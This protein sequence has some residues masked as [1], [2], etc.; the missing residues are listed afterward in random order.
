M[1]KLLSSVKNILDDNSENTSK[2]IQLY[3]I[4]KIELD[5]HKIITK[6]LNNNQKDNMIKKIK[7]QY[8]LTDLNIKNMTSQETYFRDLVRLKIDDEHKSNIYFYKKN[9]KYV[10]NDDFMIIVTE[11][12]NICEE[13]FPIISKY[14]NTESKNIFELQINENISVIF[15]QTKHS[16]V[17]IDDGLYSV[18]INI[19]DIDNKTSL[20][21]INIIQKII[22]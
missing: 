20:F 9:M 15:S 22:S 19:K 5:G 16:T 2:N 18:S 12:K 10:K 8:N 21:D 13:N 11:T 6:Q 4:H 17:D 7:K 3:I 14:H 1:K